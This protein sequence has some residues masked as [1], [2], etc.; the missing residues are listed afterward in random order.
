[1]L[2]VINND[3]YLNRGE[4]AALNFKLWNMDGTPFVLPPLPTVRSLHSIAKVTYDPVQDIVFTVP[5]K[6]GE[7][8]FTL[9]IKLTEERPVKIL[10][11][12][13]GAAS[14]YYE[15]R[16]AETD[17]ECRFEHGVGI[18][19]IT[20]YGNTID[21]MSYELD[22]QTIV[23]TEKEFGVAS[24]LA[25]TVR[26]STY[27]KVVMTKFLN[28]CA[29]P[30]FNGVLDQAPYGWNKFA[31]VRP[32]SEDMSFFGK[33]HVLELNG[34]YYHILKTEHGFSQTP[35]EFEIVVPLLP[36]DTQDLEASDYTYDLIAYHGTIKNAE[37]FD[38]LNNDFP[39]EKI[40]WKKELIV[41]H[42]FIIGDSHN[43]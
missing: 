34:N 27:D 10:F 19:R 29:P 22:G 12:L 39:L 28:M 30:I 17:F 25:L 33:Y 13:K 1:M 2:K 3:I 32:A 8:G 5:F 21:S 24:V 16:E 11:W 15:S 23:L 9:D 14:E 18:Q 20:V 31:S 38:E 6:I 4:A 41:P 26:S 43:A 42:K 35:Y 40:L 36:E 7:Q 37:V